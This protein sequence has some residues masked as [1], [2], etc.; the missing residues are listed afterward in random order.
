MIKGQ[1]NTR[2]AREMVKTVKEKVIRYDN[3]VK[4]LRLIS[5]AQKI[6]LLSSGKRKR[7]WKI[8]F[9]KV[10]FLKMRHAHPLK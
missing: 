6:I 1:G 8:L 5:E 2:D 4:D 10:Y 7:K 3:I 9:L